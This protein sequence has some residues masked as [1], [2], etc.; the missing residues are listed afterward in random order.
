MSSSRFL[1]V[2]AMRRTSALIVVVPPTL[3]NSLLLQDAEEL[4][5]HG[6]GE[7][8]DL[9]EEEGSA[10][11]KLEAPLSRGD[12]AREGSLLMAEELAFD[13]PPRGGPRS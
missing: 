2:A 7:V 8:A 10:L 1:F 6:G 5:L 4:D 13:H 12:C 3:S 11:R 9:V